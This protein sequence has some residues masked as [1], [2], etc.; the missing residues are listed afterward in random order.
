MH[1]VAVAAVACLIT[2]HAQRAQNCVCGNPDMTKGTQWGKEGP[3][4][5]HHGNN[6]TCALTTQHIEK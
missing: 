3:L 4:G 2:Q 6:S 5:K 1:N